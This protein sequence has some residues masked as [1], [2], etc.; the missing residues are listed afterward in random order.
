MINRSQLLAPLVV[1]LAVAF[2]APA[3]AQVFTPTYMSP[4]IS[5]D[6]GVYLSDGPG[7]L[8]IEGVLRRGALG[9]RAGF[10]DIGDGALM[11]GG[12]YRHRIAASAPLEFAF[13]AGAQGVLGD[14]DAAGGQAG[15]TVG[16]TF[17]PPDSRLTI[18]SYI[19]PRIAIVDGFGADDDLEVDLLADLGT[20]LELTSSLILRFGVSLGDGADLGIGL[21]WRR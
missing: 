1:L 6:L 4:R 10:A 21:A 8:A 15:V 11:I 16:H 14:A 5:D 18:T 2:A 20:D 7:D 19:H 17:L 9:L 12:E 3:R 13:T